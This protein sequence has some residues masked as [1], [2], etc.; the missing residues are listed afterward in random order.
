[1]QGRVS[2]DPAEPAGPDGSPC[3]HVSPTGFSS[4]LLT[5][6]AQRFCGRWLPGANGPAS[7]FLRLGI[8]LLALQLLCASDPRTLCVRQL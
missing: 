6:A 8:N 1:M 4:P 7:L 5:A 3:L 2:E